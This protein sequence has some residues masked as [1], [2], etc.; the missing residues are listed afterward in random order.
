MDF[1][2]D[3]DDSDDDARS[4]TTEPAMQH[5]ISEQKRA[6]ELGFRTVDP[7]ASPAERR[8]RDALV[9]NTTASRSFA[10]TSAAGSLSF[11]SSNNSYSNAASNSRNGKWAKIPAAPVCASQA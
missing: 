3:S 4:N 8:Q 1:D 11:G 10:G 2:S 9:T 7:I 6:Q 5:A